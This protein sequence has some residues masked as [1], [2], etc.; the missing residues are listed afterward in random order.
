MS[1]SK[2]KSRKGKGGLPYTVP[3]IQ[4]DLQQDG[5][6]G[7]PEPF[8]VEDFAGVSL[9]VESDAE[10]EMILPWIHFSEALR[11][12]EQMILLFGD[13]E[14]RLTFDF[15]KM[16]EAGYRVG[17]ILTGIHSQKLTWLRHQ[18]EQGLSVTAVKVEDEEEEK[19]AG[20]G[21]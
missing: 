20:T 9:G 10:V 1:S 14:I 5:P 3:D 2:P 6:E 8:K 11:K 19:E 7:A 13:W 18:P 21:E 12:N 17:E 16:S 4:K 15:K